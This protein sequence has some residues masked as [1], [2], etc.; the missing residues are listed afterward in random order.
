MAST[1]MST[2]RTAMGAPK[3]TDKLR[4]IA[5]ALL[6][7]DVKG[8]LAAA[9]ALPQEEL[10]AHTCKNYYI[11]LYTMMK[12]LLSAM[13]NPLPLTPPQAQE[14]LDRINK[15]HELL[16]FIYEDY[17]RM[18]PGNVKSECLKKVSE[19]SGLGVDIRRVGE[20][21]YRKSLP[22]PKS[23]FA[24]P[25][26]AE[27][28]A[29]VQKLIKDA[30]AKGEQDSVVQLQARLNALR[31][32][33]GLPPAFPFKNEFKNV[34]YAKFYWQEM[35]KLGKKTGGGRRRRQGRRGGTK[36]SKKV[37]RKTRRR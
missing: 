14:G 1:F 2:I 16:K 28:E 19:I 10:E 4:A 24:S 29:Y 18:A 32:T 3:T 6:K 35:E 22:A 25:S 30:Y 8:G 13:D 12:D 7:G 36:K 31:A 34:A 27:V 5:S 17:A 9:E 15:Q 20:T 11:A 23:A 21:F 26:Q 37:G 33:P